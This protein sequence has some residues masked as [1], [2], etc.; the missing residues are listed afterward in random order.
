MSDTDKLAEK[1]GKGGIT[2]R[3]YEVMS[4]SKEF[5]IDFHGFQILVILLDKDVCRHASQ[6]LTLSP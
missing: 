1:P 6:H 2:Y 4:F 5:Q 3:P